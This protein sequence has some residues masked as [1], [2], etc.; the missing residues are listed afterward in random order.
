MY[1][2]DH[3]PDDDASSNWDTSCEHHADV[4]NLLCALLSGHGIDCAVTTYR[5]SHDFPSAAD[6]LAVA[7]PWL[8]CKLGTP[9]VP[10]QQLPGGAGGPVDG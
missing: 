2:A 5:D 6:G 9:G 8:A 7:L 3:P 4:A 1:R 10:A